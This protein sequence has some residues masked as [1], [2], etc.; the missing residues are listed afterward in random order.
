MK[1]LS[2]RQLAVVRAVAITLFDDGCG[3]VSDDRVAFTMR[4][5]RA[6]VER[7]GFQ[8]RVALRAALLVVQLA[9]L[10]LLGRLVRFVKLGPADRALCLVRL[11]GSRLGLVLVL[12]KTT[13]CLHWFE[14]PEV[15]ARTGYDGQGLIG[16][17]WVVD[18]EPAAAR[19]LPLAPQVRE[20]SAA[21]GA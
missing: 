17:A 16:P 1:T 2:P 9:P 18:P 6:Y 21:E 19:K 13:L 20:A 8:T 15:L 4:E 11:E 7:V 14:H 10:L 12:L 3:G 5:L